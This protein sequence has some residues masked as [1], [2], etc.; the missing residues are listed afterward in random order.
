MNLCLILS[1]TLAFGIGRLKD[2]K[3]N[4]RGFS[5][6]WKTSR[7]IHKAVWKTGISIPMDFQVLGHVA[8]PRLYRRFFLLFLLFPRVQEPAAIRLRLRV[9]S[10]A[11]SLCVMFDGW[12]DLI[13]A[14]CLMF[15]Y[16]F[17]FRCFANGQWLTANGCFVEI[18]CKDI[19]LF[20]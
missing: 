7:F 12:A 20:C 4:S 10:D 11:L 8:V 9:L 18:R 1:F 3:L 6:P 16:W 17:V 15:S 13:C 19:A 14:L 2:G 5:N